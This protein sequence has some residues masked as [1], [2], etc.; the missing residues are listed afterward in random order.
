MGDGGCG[1]AERSSLGGWGGFYGD[2]RFE[3]NPKRKLKEKHR[4]RES[5]RVRGGGF[6]VRVVLT[7]EKEGRV[8][9]PQWVRRVAGEL[10][11]TASSHL[12][13]VPLSP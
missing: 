9:R 12:A 7:E 5:S 3:L 10:A 6:W 8:Q 4:E 1:K 2:M 11:W 13:S